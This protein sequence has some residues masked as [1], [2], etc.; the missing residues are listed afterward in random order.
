MRSTAEF[1][2]RVPYVEQTIDV[3]AELARL[4]KESEGLEKAIASKEKQLGNE[5][6]RSRA[7]EKVIR[8]MQ[9]ALAA[10]KT[11]LEKLRD[12]KGKLEG[13]AATAT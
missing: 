12:R 13:G 11:E 6:F 10:Q 5:T 8:E 7:P 4:N 9:E 2:I 3:A 1:D